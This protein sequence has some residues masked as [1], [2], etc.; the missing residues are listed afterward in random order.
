MNKYCDLYSHNFNLDIIPL[1]LFTDCIYNLCSVRHLYKY[2][3]EP[4]IYELIGCKPVK[5]SMTG[6]PLKQISYMDYL[7]KLGF[8]GVC[9]LL[10]KKMK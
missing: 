5:S 4:V 9:L 8:S 2:P 3:A 7:V 1:G 10:F 6:L